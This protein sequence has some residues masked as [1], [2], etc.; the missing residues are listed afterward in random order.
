M[1]SLPPAPIRPDAFSFAQ[2]VNDAVRASIAAECADLRGILEANR[3]G[4]S[5]AVER[6][7]RTML[8]RKQTP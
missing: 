3:K 6:I 7:A 5:A 4:D 2:S 8:E 1:I